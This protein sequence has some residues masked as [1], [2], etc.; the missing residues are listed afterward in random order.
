MLTLLLSH[1]FNTNA[2]KACFWC[3]CYIVS[4]TALLQAIR[5]EVAPVIECSTSPSE[6]ATTLK[7]CPKLNSVYREA[8]RYTAATGS[9]R[10]SLTTSQL[11]GKTICPHT[12]I[13]ITYRGMLTDHDTFGR[14]SDKFVWDRFLRDGELA[15]GLGYRPF[16]DGVGQC[17]GRFLAQLEILSLVALAV[18]RFEIEAQSRVPDLNTKHPSLGIMGPA[19][20]QDMIVRLTQRVGS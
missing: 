9:V 1:R 12:D 16:G 10:E 14:D 18:T 19:S 11:S 17:P 2:W 5:E 8:L 13:I 15:K 6:L 7:H 3:M 4:D 20:G